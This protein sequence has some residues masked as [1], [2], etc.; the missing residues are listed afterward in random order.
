VA[1]TFYF[2][3]SSFY[4][5]RDFREDKTYVTTEWFV[6][7]G[8]PLFPFCSYRLKYIGPGKPPPFPLVGTSETFRVY[9]KTRPNLRQV[10]CVYGFVVSLFAWIALVIYAS[11][12]VVPVLWEKPSLSWIPVTACLAPA[13]LPW[14]LRIRAKRRLRA[15][16]HTTPT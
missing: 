12:K 6:I 9:E 7:L 8:I 3:G 13:F 15:S 5:M 4:G 2:V 14:L 16:N 10:L 11:A 1:G